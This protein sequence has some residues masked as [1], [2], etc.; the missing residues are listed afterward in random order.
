MKFKKLSKSIATLIVALLL[1]ITTYSQCT[2]NT[3]VIPPVDT[4]IVTPP[5]VVDTVYNT[6]YTNQ[7]NNNIGNT[8][9]ENNIINYI[10]THYFNRLSIYNIDGSVI[11]SESPKVK[12][13][14]TRCHQNGIKVDIV[15]S[16]TAFFPT[17]TTYL[18]NCNSNLEK[19]D[20]IMW[21]NEYYHSGGW[22]AFKPNLKVAWDYAKSK[23]PQLDVS[24]YM[25]HLQADGTEVAQMEEL[26]HYNDYINFH[27]YTTSPQYSYISSRVHFGG[28]AWKNLID[29]GIEPVG[30]KAKGGVI[31]SAEVKTLGAANDFMGAYFMTKNFVTAKQVVDNSFNADVFTN[32]QYITLKNTVVFI[33]EFYTKEQ[34]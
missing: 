8:I 9:W 33:D 11:N 23:S 34:K 30:S 10:K 4:V 19:P 29:K 3:V 17:L 18:N 20:G 21:E 14:F 1:S 28:Q 2:C 31:F 16:S 27:E 25:A 15:F 13:F 24:F 32:K 6:L 22:L 5:V 12:S 7:Y 26:F